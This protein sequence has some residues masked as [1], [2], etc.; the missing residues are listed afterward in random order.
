MI[1]ALEACEVSR[2][3]LYR[4]VDW[5]WKKPA[6]TS[7]GSVVPY[8]G[9]WIETYVGSLGSQA[10][11]GRTLYR[12]VDWN[13]FGRL[14]ECFCYCRTLYRYVDWNRHIKSIITDIN[15]VPYIGTWIETYTGTASEQV[16]RVVPYIGTWIETE[17]WRNCEKAAPCRTLYRYVDWNSAARYCSS[18]R[19]SRTLYRYVDWNLLIVLSA[20]SPRSYLI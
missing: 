13:M 9:T 6:A 10:G 20:L 18:C 19:L 16:N 17:P 3:T 2:R 1:R 5:N 15:V 8:I 14:G 4:Y 12:Y 11:L 7:H